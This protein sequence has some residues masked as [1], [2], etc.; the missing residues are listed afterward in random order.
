MNYIKKYFSFLFL[1]IA[2]ICFGQNRT[3]ELEIS[4]TKTYKE[5][6]IHSHQQNNEILKFRGK[7]ANGSLW[8]FSIP[9]SIVKKSCFLGFKGLASTENF[10][11]FLGVIQ[12]DTLIGHYVN[13]GNNERLIRL[14]GIYHHTAHMVNNQYIPELKKTVTIQQWNTDYFFIDSIPNQFLKENMID[15]SFGFFQSAN[16]YDENLADMASKIKTNPNSQYYMIRLSMTPN[17]YKSKKDIEQLYDLFSDE[18]RNSYYGKIVY[19]N[20]STFKIANVSL[21][22]CDTKIEE[23]IVEDPNKY[24]LL[25]FSAS[26]CGPC[27]KKIPMLKKIYK[28]TRKVLNMVYVTTDDEKTLPGWK[29]L[30]RKENIPW[31]SLSLN[32]NNELADMWNIKAIPDYL[33]IN[34]NWEAQKISLNDENDI[35]KLYSIIQNK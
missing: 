29:T 4:G 17:Y 8:I 15:P 33:L 3:V 16:G 6:Y 26:W 13:F 7:T 22:N 10:I 20:F 35:N 25:I 32:N 11:E 12:M 5:V 24:T 34:P 27:R 23:R 30:M 1:T 31:R 28:E 14:K 18:M 2:V 19:N 9:D 21:P